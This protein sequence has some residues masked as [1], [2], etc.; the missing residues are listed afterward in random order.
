MRMLVLAATDMELEKC[1]NHF[2]QEGKDNFINFH[3]IGVGAISAGFHTQMYIGQYRPEL[4]ILGGIAGSFD[5]EITLGETFVVQSD[6][7][8]TVGVEENGIWKDVFDMGF[9]GKDQFPHQN[10]FLQNP[11]LEKYSVVNLPLVNSISVDEITT[12]PKRQQ[13]YLDKYNPVLESMEGAAFHFACL[14]IGVPFLQ[15]RSVSNYVG[16]RDK[17]KWDFK[18]ALTNLNDK[19]IDLIENLI[20]Q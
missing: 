5:R 14:H 19:M 18:N 3:T 15:I 9:V 6:V 4:V 12:N 8:A 7:Q 13:A 20:E 17:S 11:F 1:R 16:E 10:G 2:Q